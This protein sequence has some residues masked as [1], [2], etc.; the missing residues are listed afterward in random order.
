MKSRFRNTCNTIRFRLD[1]PISMERDETR[2]V[3]DFVA[4]VSSTALRVHE[5]SAPQIHN[6]INR[7]TR[8]LGI[9]TTPEVFIKNEQSTNAYAV[10]PGNSERLVIVLN[11]GIVHL[12]SPLELEFVIA[13]ELGHFGMRHAG[14]MSDTNTFP[15]ELA[16]LQ[17][18]SQ[19]RCQE[20]SADRIGLIGSQSIDIAAKVIIKLASGLTDEQLHIDVGSFIDQ[21]DKE[22]AEM[23]REWELAMSHPSLP[24][25]LWAL[26]QF[27][28]TSLYNSLTDRGAYGNSFD[29]IEERVV[30]HFN[31]LGDGRLSEM[32]D[33]FCSD[34]ILWCAMAMIMHDNRI[35]RDEQH[36]LRELVG[37]SL[38]NKA[39]NFVKI[40]GMQEVQKKHMEAIASLFHTSPATRKKF[41]G[42]V[43]TFAEIV[44]VDLCEI[45]DLGPFK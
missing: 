2:V 1:K 19:Q 21:L 33:N 45:I 32:E 14:T 8:R 11:S 26:I 7:V 36:A 40:H 18:Q 9:L 10:N 5:R 30:E 41:V 35:D 16:F 37:E 3:A 28:H 29:T 4:R 39:L 44:D 23:S 31:S 12:L 15:N 25:R 43:I 22:T 17:E 20:I 13:H 27:S 24:L 42:T 38:A 34:A 6:A